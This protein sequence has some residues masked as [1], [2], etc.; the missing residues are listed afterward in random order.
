M[1]FQNKTQDRYQQIIIVVCYGKMT[2][3]ATVTR[4][5][6][7]NGLDESGATCVRAMLLPQHH[8][9]ISCVAQCSSKSKQTTTADPISQTLAAVSVVHSAL[10]RTHV[11]FVFRENHLL[12]RAFTLSN[13]PSMPTIQRRRDELQQQQRSHGS[14]VINKSQFFR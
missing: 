9:Y 2:A 3:T 8:Y 4:S 5:R 10:C 11:Q 7:D 12:A 1:K 13:H 14:H 6:R